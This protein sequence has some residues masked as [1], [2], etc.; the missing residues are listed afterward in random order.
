MTS[1]CNHRVQRE[2]NIVKVLEGKKKVANNPKSYIQRKYP[3]KMK[4]KLRYCQ[5]R[6]T[7]KNLLL[8][9]LQHTKC[10]RKL[11]RLSETIPDGNLDLQEGM[12]DITNG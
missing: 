8:G 3:S 5:I 6:E 10:Q 2:E 9:G 1:T 4:A 7:K 11:Q 12:K